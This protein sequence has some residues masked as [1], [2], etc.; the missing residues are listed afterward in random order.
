MSVSVSVTET[1]ALGK[2]PGKVSIQTVSQNQ[3][4]LPITMST[5]ETV[6]VNGAELLLLL[7]RCK[8]EGK[9]I[10][11]LQVVGVSSYRATI[12]PKRGKEQAS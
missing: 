3:A 6:E 7:E 9:T 10:G 1:L 11:I 8:A 5:A 2:S 12:Y 4:E